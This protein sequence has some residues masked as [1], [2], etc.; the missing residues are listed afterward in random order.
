MDI[1]QDVNVKVDLVLFY[2]CLKQECSDVTRIAL[3]KTSCS[4]SKNN[5]LFA[6]NSGFLIQLCLCL[7][8][9][10]A[11]LQARPPSNGNTEITLPFLT[12]VVKLS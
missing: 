3:E 6:W 1:H 12:A 9:Y 2:F 11:V 10:L 8:G 5:G 7:L 4:G